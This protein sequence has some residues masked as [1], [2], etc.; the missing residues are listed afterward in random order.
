LFTDDITDG[1]HPLAF[2][3]SVIPLS[4][5][6]SVGKTKKSFADGFTD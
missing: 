5:A 4:V 3:S 1:L 2:L 6:I